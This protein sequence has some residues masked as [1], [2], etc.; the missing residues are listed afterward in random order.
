MT[1]GLR[2]YVNQQTSI[3]PALQAQVDAIE[4]DVLALELAFAALDAEVN[5]LPTGT[6]S[7]GYAAITADSSV[8]SGTTLLNIAGLSITWTAVANRRYRISIHGSLNLTVPSDVFQAT[9][10][11][12]GGVMR[13][14]QEITSAWDQIVLT[15]IVV[16]GAGSI[17]RRLSLQRESGTGVAA[18]AANATYPAF[19]LVEDIG[20]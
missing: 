18:V 7:G 15:E 20:T 4:D 16:P 14:R 19:I 17:T 11:D 10:R 12:G 5:L 8:T 3:P 13:Q 1:N 9:I 2:A 6:I